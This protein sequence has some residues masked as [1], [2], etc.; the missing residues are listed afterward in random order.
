MIG[1]RRYTH[2]WLGLVLWAATALQAAAQPIAYNHPQL[3]WE[4][5][6]TE[7][8]VIHFHQG[9]QWLARTAADIAEDVY[10]PITRFYG[11]EPDGKLHI[12]LYDTDDYSNGGAWYYNNKIYI[13]AT[14]LDIPLRGT[15]N[16]LRNVITHEFTHMIQLGAARKAPR[17]LQALYLQVIDYE[18]EKRDDVLYGFPN[19]IGAYPLPFTIVP[20]WFAE[21]TAQFQYPGLGYDSWDTERDMLLRMK[22]LG[23]DLLSFWDMESFGHSGINNEAV[24]N[25]G[26]D[27][28]LYLVDRF[29]LDVL[30]RLSDDL[31]RPFTVSMNRSLK[32]VTGVEGLQLWRD[33]QTHL[34]ER[35]ERDL[36]QI[37]AHEQAG[38][39]LTTAGDGNRCP[40]AAP[41]DSLVYFLSN[42]GSDYLGLTSLYHLAPPD[43]IL[44]K[45]VGGARGQFAVLPDGSGWVYAK[46]SPVTKW[47]HHFRDLY[48]QYK[49][50]KPLQLTQHQRLTRPAISPDGSRVACVVNELGSNRLAWLELPAIDADSLA[51]LSRRQRRAR[52]PAPLHFL[53]PVE[54]GRQYYSPAWLN[55]S[56]LIV[57][58]GYL[59]GRDIVTVD[60]GGGEFTPLLQEWYD[61][62]DPCPA[63]DGT[64]FYYASDRTGIY[65]IYYHDL[66]SGIDTP[67]TNVL[68]AALQPSVD[69]QGTLYFT[70]YTS[71]GFQIARLVD[72]PPVDPAHM[73][74]RQ[75]DGNWYPPSTFDDRKPTQYE[76]QPDQLTFE[77]NFFVPRIA[78]DGG[79]FKPGGFLF[80]NDIMGNIDILLAFGI[81]NR[82]DYD[83][84]GTASFNL[85][86]YSWFLESFFIGRYLDQEFDDPFRIVG[87]TDEGAP[88]YDHF[89]IHYRFNLTE[90]TGGIKRRFNDRLE[91]EFS[92]SL[93]RYANLMDFGGGAVFRYTYLKG[94][95]LRTSLDWQRTRRD[96]SIDG[97]ISPRYGENLFVRLQAGHNLFIDDFEVA[98]N[99]LLDQIYTS[100]DFLDLHYSYH[101]YFALPWTKYSGWGLHSR[102]DL[103]SRN[104]VDDF[105]HVYLGG[106]EGMRG[107]SYYSLG[108]TYAAMVKLDVT[109]PLWRHIHHKVWH[110][111]PKQLYLE[112]YGAAGSAWT[113]AFRPEEIRKEAGG[114]L[115]LALTSW[116]I[117]PTAVTWGASWGFDRFRNE[118]TLGK[119]DYGREWRYYLKILFNFEEIQRAND[120]HRPRY[121]PCGG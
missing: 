57:A 82:E 87:E 61:E 46:T 72:P 91:G 13:W 12:I 32:R 108:G 112:L 103:L 2:I 110:L 68:G 25:Q 47:G 104:D 73:T 11:Y 77:S 114:E 24:Y 94:Y 105:F 7:H 96:I 93:S 66:A 49:D 36:A 10:P 115:R 70:R 31:K 58:T 37:T 111:Y 4:R 5:I 14:S 53:T 85:G 34:R 63:P 81:H 15:H 62:R 51:E 99:G 50:G 56:T 41:G 100:Y 86:R 75:R 90:V 84:Y 121:L 83:L 42:K 3:E 43:T 16:W 67:L 64:G 116:G 97:D 19:Q 17:W 69:S 101:R 20:V 78:W 107:Y 26:Y 71:D 8:F 35:Y 29:G 120:Q 95:Q 106:L 65:N 6:E 52:E 45:D 88:I 54:E 1:T 39:L 23:D 119:V 118:T 22:V 98:A 102:G 80:T 21:G 48:L 9:E 76:V 92:G 109:L 60:L 44:Q 40:V 38:E 55:D 79:V 30:A 33:W 27:F 89:K 28:V 59:Q 18:R 113:D 74:Y 117:M